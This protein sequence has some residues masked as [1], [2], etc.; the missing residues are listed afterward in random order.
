MLS[1][2]HA[3]QALL[4]VLILAM[5]IGMTAASLVVVSAANAAA[6]QNAV[7]RAIVLTAS[8]IGVERVKQGIAQGIFDSQFAS[9]NDQATISDN[10]Y[11]PGGRLYSSYTARV[12]R[13]YGSVDEQYLVISQGST[14]WTTRQVNVVLRRTSPNLPDVAAAMTFYNPNAATFFAGIVPRISGLDTNIPDDIPF[15]ELKASD[16]VSG[17]GDGPDLVGLGLHDDQS[18]IDIGIA[19]GT[20][21]SRVTG[22]DGSGGSETGS[23]YNV[24][25]P[26]PSGLIDTLTAADVVELGEE[27]ARVADYLYDGDVWTGSDGETLTDGNF[28]TVEHPRIVVLRSDSGDKIRLTGNTTGVGILIIDSEVEIGGT[29][30]YAGLVIVTDR[31]DATV[32]VTLKGT[33]LLMGAI[34]GASTSPDATSGL[35]LCGTADVFFSREALLLA[36]QALTARARF[37]TIA[38]VEVKPNPADLEIEDDLPTAIFP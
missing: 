26:N 5:V 38:Y 36:Q 3:G 19:L 10:I 25:S 20:G 8:E 14:G 37:Q 16:C 32:S 30:N 18:V 17:S 24:A 35:S 23:V 27:F 33:P 15:A 13:D 34:I 4:A 9:Q 1:G 21:A 28:G 11:T 7:Q 22:T 12:T 2:K 6:S 31:G 29:F